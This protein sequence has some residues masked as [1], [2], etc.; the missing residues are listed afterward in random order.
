MTRAENDSNATHV[1]KRLDESHTK[2]RFM[3]QNLLQ[4]KRR[5]KKQ[6]PDIETSIDVLKLV[7]Q[8]RVSLSL[9]LNKSY[10]KNQLFLKF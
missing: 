3:E 2:Y 6:I 4:K 10:F 1:L 8:K 5:L 7:K 9:Y